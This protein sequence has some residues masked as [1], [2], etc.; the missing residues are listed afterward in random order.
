MSE[1]ELDVKYE[2]RQAEERQQQRLHA[3]LWLGWLDKDGLLKWP[4]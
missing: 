4:S 2:S 3:N 1:P